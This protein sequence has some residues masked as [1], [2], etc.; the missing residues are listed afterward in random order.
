MA[1][2]KKE[3]KINVEQTTT[4][5][6]IPDDKNINLGSLEGKEMIERSFEK[7]GAGRSILVDKNNRVISGNKSLESFINTDNKKVIVVETTGDTLVAVKR[8]DIDLDTKEGRELAIAD[9][10]TQKINYVADAEVVEML[11][12]EH[13]IDPNEWGFD[14]DEEGQPKRIVEEDIRPFIKTHILLSFPP[15]MLIDIAP[16]LE[17]IRKISGVEIEQ[18][19]N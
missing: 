13:G 10:Q 14:I 18:S 6:I 15:Q 11:T 8:T 1:E 7:F 12:N 9:N 3:K 16:H 2:E 5:A 4:D 19:S 17:A